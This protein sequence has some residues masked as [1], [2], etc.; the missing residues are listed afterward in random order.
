M[1][2]EISLYPLGGS[3]TQLAGYSC[4][5]AGALEISL[6]PLKGS[7]TQLAGYTCNCVV[8]LWNKAPPFGSVYNIAHESVLGFVLYRE[9]NVFLYRDV[10]FLFNI[11][12][13]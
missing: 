11:T 13:V 9:Q 10:Q 3:I 12:T 5:Y 7:I 1:T 4:N 2:L 6:H 8:M